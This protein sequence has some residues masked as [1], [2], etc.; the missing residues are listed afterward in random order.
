MSNPFRTART[1]AR[2][3]ARITARITAATAATALAVGLGVVAAPSASAADNCW[4]GD[5]NRWYCHNVPGAPVFGTVGDNHVY[6][7]PNTV[8]GYLNTDPSWFSC[9]EDNQAWVGGPHPTRWLLTTAD[10]GAVGFVR[11]TDITSETDPV[12]YC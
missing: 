3:T 4:P 11:D 10:N 5:A 6:P 7:D 12:P 2:A 8:V 9:K 1:T